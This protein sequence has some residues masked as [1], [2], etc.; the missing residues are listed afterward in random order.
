[1]LLAALLVLGF[2]PLDWS[3]PWWAWVLGVIFQVS[4]NLYRVNMQK[5]AR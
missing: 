3:F 2:G 4:E 1:M 5:K